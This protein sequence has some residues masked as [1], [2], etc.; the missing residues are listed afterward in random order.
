L[1]LTFEG[2]SAFGMMIVAM[3]FTLEK[4]LVWVEKN[5]G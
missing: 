5:N 1:E 4:K 2:S 3:V